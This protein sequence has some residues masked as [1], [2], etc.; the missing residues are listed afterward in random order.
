MRYK[1]TLTA[2]T[3]APVAMQAL[4]AMYGDC[5]SWEAVYAR[6]MRE[7][8]LKCRT[9]SSLKRIASEIVL[10]LR[11]L[12]PEELS[13]FVENRQNERNV[14]T[15]LAVCRAYGLVG[16]FAA[17]SLHEA[18]L[19]G[20]KTFSK[21][22]YEKFINGKRTLHPELDELSE[23]TYEKVRQVIFKMLREAGYL[24]QDGAII[25][26]VMDEELMNFIP[27]RELA[28]FPMYI[29]GRQA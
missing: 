13:R 20:Q 27:E 19:T 17:E 8:T 4:G 16:D 25:P 14:F 15:W 1:F 7:N 26:L 5:G 29:R 2:V 10:R 23:Q 22:D 6:A 24:D 21:N 11:K 18:Y 28:F 12:S 3:L 9:A